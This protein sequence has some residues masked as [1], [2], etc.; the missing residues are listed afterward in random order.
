[1]NSP[2][3]FVHLSCLAALLGL[4]VLPL[5]PARA[6]TPGGAAGGASGEEAAEGQR[7]EVV[8]YLRRIH[9]PSL[10]RHACEATTAEEFAAWQA[11]AR[12]A[13]LD[14]LRLDAI[15]HES[16]DFQPLARLDP[17]IEDLGDF[18]RQE[19]SLETEPDVRV[20]FWLLKPKG[21]G[22]FPAL[23]TANGHGPSRGAAGIYHSDAERDRSLRED[24]DIGPQAV[25]RGF[26]ALVMS[27]RGIGQNPTS[28]G[29]AD[30]DKR[31]AGKDC[32][33]H[34]WHA[35]AAGRTLTG[36]RVWDVMRVIDWLETLPEAELSGLVMTGN[37]GGGM[38]THY[39][40][41]AD[42]RIAV[43][44]PSSSFNGYLHEAG[45]LV[46]CQCN[47][48]PGLLRFGQFW[49]VAGLMS[50]AS[51]PPP[52]CRSATSTTS[53]TRATASTRR[54]C[55][56]S[57]P[58]PSVATCVR[59]IDFPGG[60]RPPF[61]PAGGS[62]PERR[63]SDPGCRGPRTSARRR[64]CRAIRVPARR[65]RRGRPRDL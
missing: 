18:T 45:N 44:M 24:R 41:A 15:R 9:D 32:V 6:Q 62:R 42:E 3:L 51:T 50:L 10:A 55:G 7:E 4:L 38:L 17:E 21:S 59:G 5:G 13:Y 8:R 35:L 60:G 19:G 11:E 64:P 56:T 28:F 57:P 2:S 34:N 27:T 20:H 49:D 14:L 22:P 33:A 47:H 12:A 40:A 58:A 30:L 48:V 54:R 46:H 39:A 36:E 31:N 29:V 37:S 26:M 63:A 25:A 23:L 61:N 65:A 52:A 16:G 43:A 53:G 1:M